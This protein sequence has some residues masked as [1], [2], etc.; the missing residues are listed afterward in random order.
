M[1]LTPTKRNQQPPKNMK[2]LNYLLFGLAAFTLAS[3]SQ[4]DVFTQGNPNGITNVRINLTT[5]ELQTRYSDGKAAKELKYALYEST[6]DGVKK[7]FEDTYDG[8]FTSSAHITLQVANDHSYKV[9]FWA[10]TPEKDK[11]N[12]YTLSFNNEGAKIT[13]DYGS[14]ALLANTDNLDAFYGCL[15]LDNVSGDA[16]ISFQLKRPFAQINVGTS[17]YNYAEK[18]LKIE[19]PTKSSVTVSNVAT[20]LNLISGEVNGEEEATFLESYINKAAN[21]YPKVGYEYLAMAYVLAGEKSDNHDVTFSYDQGDNTKSRTVYAVPLQRNHRTNIYGAILTSSLDLDIEKDPNWGKDEDVILKWDGESKTYP[22]VTEDQV[23][24]VQA[25]D[26]IGLSELIENGESYEG[27]TI[28]LAN[29][30]DMSGH[31]FPMLGVAQRSGAAPT[32]ASKVFKGV[33]DGNGKK[34]SNVKITYEAESGKAIVGFIPSLDGEGAELKNLTFEKLVIEGGN[35]EQAG[36][37]GT[38]TGGAKVS[39]V[40]VMSGSI[41]STEAAGGIVGRLMKAGTVENCENHARVSASAHNVGG[42]VGAAYYIAS[43]KTMTVSGCDNYG[44]ITGKF[45]VAGIVGLSCGDVTDCNNYATLVKGENASVGGVVGEQKA[46]GKIENCKNYADVEG[47]EGASTNYGAGGIVGWV[48][49][50]TDGSYPTADQNTIIVS[51][52]VNNGK[53]IK[54]AS[55][56]GGIVGAWYSDGL[57]YGNT[58]FA[59]TITASGNFAAGIV[60]NSQWTEVASDGSNKD[61]YTDDLKLEVYNNTTYTSLQDIKAAGCPDIFIYINNKEKTVEHDNKNPGV[62][63]VNN[64]SALTSALAQASEGSLIKLAE[65]TYTALAFNDKNIYNTSNVIIDANGAVFEGEN[66]LYLNPSVTVKNATFKNHITNHS[67][68]YGPAAAWGYISGI[69]ENCT[70]DGEDALRYAIV[71][72]QVKFVK[73]IFTASDEY[74]FH[75][76]SGTASS[77]ILEGCTIKGYTTLSGSVDQYEISD[78]VINANGKGFG[79][80]GLYKNTKVTNCEFNILGEKDH[81]DIAFKA[82]GMNFEF[83]NCKVNGSPLTKDYDFTVAA[84]DGVDVTIDGEK[85]NLSYTGDKP[86]N[87]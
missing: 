44:E 24:V 5:S 15:A 28:V 35:A 27:K 57:C 29:D 7:L 36:V 6:G 43:G 17:D 65:G 37:V 51:G 3:C 55:G 68:K 70:F 26:L 42:I 14:E 19:V 2:K 47:G 50:T 10:A 79:G 52:C 34:I 73:C 11:N 60:G 56:V 87:K 81:Q 40:K 23:K 54:G 8:E 16:Q 39:G 74:A 31:D 18:P 22:V 85:T 33:F 75:V 80:L 41:S 61:N 49:Y 58:N 20:E 38:L 82:G 59:E 78:C 21:K 71:S 4:E 84:N 32:D 86:K 45:A 64:D 66:R 77:V 83:T 62:T 1:T 72:G 30:F 9:V 46:T 13:V 76:D 69:F 12:P 63:I 48:R 67:E 25:S 53:H